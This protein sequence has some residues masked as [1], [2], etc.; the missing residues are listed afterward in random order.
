MLIYSDKNTWG[1]SHYTTNKKHFQKP[2]KTESYH[3]GHKVVNRLSKK[4][5]K[6]VE[7]K[8]EETRPAPRQ[9]H[10]NSSRTY[11]QSRV[12]NQHAHF[13]NTTLRTKK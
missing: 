11:I 5:S 8:A 6:H 7:R 10:T 2:T 9:S 4:T 3:D 1:T 13:A 12:A